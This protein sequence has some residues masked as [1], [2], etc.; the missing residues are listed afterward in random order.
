VE[1]VALMKEMRNANKISIGKVAG[2]RQIWRPR[3]GLDG[4]IKTD[5]KKLFHQVLD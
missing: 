2:E 3:C 4:N 1:L 5:L